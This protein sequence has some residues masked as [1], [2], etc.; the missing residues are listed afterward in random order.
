MNISF[1]LNLDYAYAEA[2]RQQ[3]DALSAQKMITDLEDT[4]GAALNEITQ[5][6][7]ILPSI[8]DRVEIGSDWVVV[9]ARSF[10]QDGSVWLSVKQLEA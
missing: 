6:H 8:G 2:I 9:N 5:R 10:S 3:H 1:D 4:I 7:G